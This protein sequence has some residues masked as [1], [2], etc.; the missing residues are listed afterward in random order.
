MCTWIL[1]PSE[2]E[3]QAGLSCQVWGTSPSHWVTIPATRALFHSV[4]CSFLLQ[5]FTISIVFISQSKYSPILLTLQSLKCPLWWFLLK[6]LLLFFSM[7]VISFIVSTMTLIFI[8]FITFMYM[9]ICKGM[10]MC[11]H[12][13]VVHVMVRGQLERISFPSC[14]LFFFFFNLLC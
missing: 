13:V 8:Y 3:L 4:K 2:L 7:F 11:T 14:F 6:W 5:V 12:T 10:Y 9:Y 1:M